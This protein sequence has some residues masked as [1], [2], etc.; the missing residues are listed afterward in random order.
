MQQQDSTAVKELVSNMAQLDGAMRL[1]GAQIPPG[2]VRLSMIS[3]SP[4]TPD[5]GIKIHLMLIYYTPFR[6]ARKTSLA[7]RR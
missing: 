3:G 5:V 1:D 2:G 4:S 7:A 6:W